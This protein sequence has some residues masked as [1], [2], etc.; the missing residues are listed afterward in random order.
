MSFSSPSGGFNVTSLWDL[1]PS[2]YP[3]DP[4]S[5]QDPFLPRKK[6]TGPTFLDTEACICRR[7]A[8]PTSSAG[9]N[10]VPLWR[11]VGNQTEGFETTTSG[12]WF[13]PVYD[14][15]T[16][17]DIT[18]LPINDESNPPDTKSSLQW[19]P[20]SNSLVPG[21]DHLSVWDSA[22]TGE[23]RTSFSTSFYRAAE[24]IEQG[25]VPFDAA[26][27][28]RAG[29]VPLQIQNVSHWQSTGCL[30]GFVC[31]Y[32]YSV[33]LTILS[34]NDLWLTTL[35]K[36]AP[37][38][39]STPSRSTA[40]PSLSARRPDSGSCLARS[41]TPASPWAHSSPSSAKAANTALQVYNGLAIVP[42]VHTAIPAQHNQRS[43]PSGVS[44]RKHPST[45]PTS[46]RL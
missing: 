33:P 46:S 17:T 19:N 35:H 10:T 27:C 42:G 34:P 45:R 11:C 2:L 14:N 44:V 6:P 1:D 25:E 7:Q 24:Q 39:Q 13:R 18:A 26:P 8:I 41:T 22:C 29:A 9:G 23:N 28:W 20:E 32:P 5:P 40:L 37:T 3:R 30:P 31:R 21:S 38:I 16:I 4:S 15:E 43:V 36:Q 12:K